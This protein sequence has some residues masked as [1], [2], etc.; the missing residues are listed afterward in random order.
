MKHILALVLALGL[1]TP[2]LAAQPRS[3][4]IERVISAQ[5]QAFLKD[6]FDTAFSFA[7]PSIR[8][9]FGTA[10][11]FGQILT[12]AF[13]MVVNP[14]RVQ[15]LSLETVNGQL[16]QR[17]LIEDEKGVCYFAAYTMIDTSDGWQI[18]AIELAVVN[19]MWV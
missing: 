7:A 8:Q 2:S 10:Q 9:K 14:S 18:R 13:P 6:D 3:L 19:Q 16:V 5:F 12:K 17:V 1:A 11:R 4:E 15:F